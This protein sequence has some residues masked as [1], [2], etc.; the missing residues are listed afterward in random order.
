MKLRNKVA[1]IT[2]GSSGIGE[3]TAQLFASQGANVVIADLN[4]EKTKLVIQSFKQQGLQI[5]GIVCDVSNELDVKRL[6]DQTIKIYGKIDILFNNAGSILPKKL[7]DITMKEWDSVFN[8]NVKSMFLT[9]KYAMEHLKRSR[10]SIINMAS[11]TGVVG[12]QNNPAYS[13]TKGAVVAFTKAMAIDLAPNQVRVNAIS[14]AGVY[15][16]LLEEWIQRHEDPDKARESQDQSHM[17][18]R[19]ATPGEIANI[20]LFLASNDSSF[21]TGE[22]IVADGGATIGYAAGPKPEWNHVSK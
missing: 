16:P 7:Q 12:Q 18:G 20:V 10:G 22:N 8:V 17:L 13:A 19:T 21:I 2:G 5:E 4:E 1:I 6:I 3:A 11:M 9:V 14:P 15:T